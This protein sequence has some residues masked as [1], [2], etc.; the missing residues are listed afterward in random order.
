[1]QGGKGN[2]IY[3]KGK[4]QSSSPGW[5]ADRAVPYAVCQ[6][7]EDMVWEMGIGVLDSR[8][9]RAEARPL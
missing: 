4:T 9:E 3:R 6:D 7:V 8:G 1:V 2:A 5:R